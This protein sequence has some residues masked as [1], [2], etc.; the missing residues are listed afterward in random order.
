VPPA[1]SARKILAGANSGTKWKPH[2]GGQ[3]DPGR[4]QA[5]LSG[6]GKVKVA[7]IRI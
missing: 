5:L 4:T 7:A 3:V 1:N 2:Y 6:S